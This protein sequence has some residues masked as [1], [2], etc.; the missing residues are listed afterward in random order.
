MASNLPKKIL[1]I[2]SDHSIGNSMK[3][4]L[5]RHQIKV[6]VAETYDT[7]IYLFN[8][9]L[10]PVVLLEL[11]FPEMPGLVL[12]QKWRNHETATKRHG[13]FILAAGNRND[14]E[15]EEA[16]LIQELAGIELIYKP[17]TAIQLLPYLQRAFHCFQRNQRS[18]EIETQAMTMG[19]RREQLNDALN[20]IQKNLPALGLRGIDMMRELY[21][22]HEM[23]ENALN[24]V[25]RHLSKQPDSIR[26]MNAK[27]RILLKQ[28]R[29]DEALKIMETADKKAPDNIDRINA[30][31]VAYL[32]AQMPEKSVEKMKQLIQFHPEKPEIKFNM[33][34]QLCEHG[35]DSHAQQLCRETASPLEVVRHY[36]N[37]GVAL[38]KSGRLEEALLEYERSLQFYPK[39]KENY[40][41]YYNIAL[42]QT[43][44]KL[45]AYYEKALVN[46]DECLNLNPQFEK[47]AKTREAVIA[48][49]EKL[50]KRS[51]RA[52]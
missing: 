1:L 3:L 25:D 10:Y 37:K 23:L 48:A 32:E 45:L 46:L 27:G 31:A 21:E 47:A 24:L 13:G 51:E 16:R 14:R 8:Q 29:L 6:D 42:A 33:F 36:N 11:L 26:L 52:S 4:P 20:L 39:F 15:P 35:F 49:I 5:E 22:Q 38:A 44:Y 50:R 17:F 7:A 40:R 28:G 2:D 41:I 12:L 34:A 19:K 30:L 43:N 9:N 18:S